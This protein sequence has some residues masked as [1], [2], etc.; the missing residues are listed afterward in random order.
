MEWVSPTGHSC[1]SESREAIIVSREERRF[2]IFCVTLTKRLI[3]SGWLVSLG[4]SNRI[5]KLGNAFPAMAGKSFFLMVNHLFES[6]RFVKST[7]LIRQIRRS[8]SF[9]WK[10]FDENF[11]MSFKIK[12]LSNQIIRSLVEKILGILSFQHSLRREVL[13]QICQQVACS[14]CDREFQKIKMLTVK[15]ST[16]L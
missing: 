13:A 9:Q 3:L 15:A 6:N 8:K 16:C 10:H 14:V 2:A 4:K 11:S 1:L 5:C 12:A 7:V